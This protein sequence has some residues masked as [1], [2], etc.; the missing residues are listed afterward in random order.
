LPRRYAYYDLDTHSLKT[1]ASSSAEGSTLSCRTLPKAGSMRNGCVFERQTL[2]LPTDVVAYSSLLPTPAA[3]DADRGPDYAI[4][5][6]PESGGYSLTTAV[7]L[8]PTPDAG[9]FNDGQTIETWAKR[10]EKERAKGYNGNG[11]GIPLAMA[12]KF[13]PQADSS[14][15]SSPTTHPTGITGP[16]TSPPSDNGNESTVGPPLQLFATDD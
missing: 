14:L 10:N 15:A 16:S 8:L 5:D 6:R 4:V 3:S 1:W 7:A 9:V 2:A 11:G 13:L 12:V